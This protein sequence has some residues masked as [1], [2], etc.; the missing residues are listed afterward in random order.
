MSTIFY[1]QVN[2][3][4][5]E[6]LIARGQAGTT[7]RTTRGIN[8]MVGKIANVQLEAYGTKP[9][10]ETKALPGFGVLGGKSVLGDSY[11]PSGEN[12]YLNDKLRFARRIPPIITDVSID[13]NDQSKSYINKATVNILIPDASTDIDEMESIYCKPG[14]YI[15]IQLAYPD[16]VVLSNKSLVDD[17]TPTTDQLKK[18]Y[19]NTDES[20]LKK[21]NELYF[22]G[23]I[24]TFSFNY[25]SDGSITLSFEAI[26]TSN[27][28]ADVQVYIN[29]KQTTTT[30]TTTTENQVDSLYK[31]L[32][33]EIDSI[34]ATYN[35][36]NVYEFEYLS[37]G[38]TDQS[39]LVGI[40]YTIG[41]TT[42][43]SAERM[44]SLAY[45]IDH[46]NKK[47]LEPIESQNGSTPIRINCDDKF[48]YS[49]YYEKIV[50]AD[51]MHILLWAGKS[52]SQ[53]STYKFDVNTTV[54]LSTDRTKVLKM[55]PNITE[56][57]TDGFIAK[58]DDKFVA[59]PSR[60]Y[61]NI[62]TIKQIIDK[63]TA[64]KDPSIKNFL[65]ELSSKIEQLTGNSIKL[66]LVQHPTIFDAL[67]YYDVNFVSTN[68]LV[69]EF[70]IPVFASTTGVSVVRDFTLT[71]NVPN[72]VKNMIFGIDSWKTGTQQQ[73]A[74]NPYIYADDET[75][76]TLRNEWKMQA[77]IAAINLADTK[78]E[79]VQRPTDPVVINNLSEA[80]KK[81]ITYF[82]DDIEK[83]ID[84]T[85][86]IFPMELEF[87]LDG[88]NG[89]KYGDVLQFNGLPKKYLKSFVFTVLGI[90]H[91]VTTSGEWTTTI[92][93]NPRVRIR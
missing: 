83:S 31:S 21:M 60:I 3:S 43:P 89:F 4:V 23:R 46:I 19:P 17:K 1:S 72:S 79:F 45:L 44:I 65:I 92:K 55:F 66:S 35:K 93:C 20:S 70:V 24:S 25:N 61:I 56:P 80:L 38:T 40:P 22:Q 63:I 36:N 2:R 41:N 68:T 53:C 69:E 16:D 30:T 5:Q 15:K 73:T 48:C 57:V 74:Y 64:D 71:T 26:G 12:G 10:A 81:Y 76:I 42:S 39:I 59:Y 18:L 51:P 11:L 28:Y 50:S 75:R 87:T 7:N 14:R 13:L 27:T 88:I 49:N 34:I 33:D 77:T 9:T 84:Q 54:A 52:N 91:K 85:K 58:L 6:E 32:S 78:Y 29:N 67:L 82:T 90:S 47:I 86:A 8:Y 62:Q 37:P